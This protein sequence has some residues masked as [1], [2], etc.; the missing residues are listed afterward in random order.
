MHWPWRRTRYGGADI[1]RRGSC[2][3]PARGGRAARA[4]HRARR[5]GGHDRL[6][7]TTVLGAASLILVEQAKRSSARLSARREPGGRAHQ[8]AARDAP[9]GAHTPGLAKLENGSQ[10]R[11]RGAGTPAGSEPPPAEP[12]DLLVLMDAADDRPASWH[13]TGQALGPSCSRPPECG[14]WASRS[15]RRQTFRGAS[16]CAR[17]SAPR[18]LRLG[19]AATGTF[20][21]PRQPVDDVL[22]R[23]RSGRSSV[24]VRCA[25]CTSARR[26][27]GAWC[28]DNDQCLH[29]KPAKLDVPAGARTTCSPAALSGRHP[30]VRR[31]DP[32]G[33]HSACALV[34]GGAP[35]QGARHV[36]YADGCRGA[37]TR[38][39]VGSTSLVSNGPTIAR[40]RT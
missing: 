37:H 27:A 22:P 9:G 16:G 3:G 36:P 19:Y 12:P 40:T 31:R 33:C 4:R 21:T 39:D 5:R 11:P 10:L 18:A 13:R 38:V 7:R 26:R 15:G 28:A 6:Q 24:V 2:A 25:L 30:P 20:S 8:R 29:S 1:E 17:P 14:S 35:L 23:R 34:P 32:R